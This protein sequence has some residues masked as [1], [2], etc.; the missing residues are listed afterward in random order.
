MT[1]KHQNDADP[2]PSRE[3]KTIVR[4]LRH[5]FSKEELLELMEQMATYHDE[6]AQVESNLKATTATLKAEV[7]AAGAKLAVVAAKIKARHEYRNPECV[8]VKDFAEGSFSVVRKD[9]GEIVEF[10]D[11][12]ISER[13]LQLPVVA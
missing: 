1:K 5:D 2:N 13:Q 9:T 8:E 7:A 12:S 3:T 6:Q 11:L 4:S 10:R